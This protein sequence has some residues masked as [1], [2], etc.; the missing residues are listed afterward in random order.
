MDGGTNARHSPV[1]FHP[2]NKLNQ[3]VNGLF[4]LY[5][6]NNLMKG[7]NNNIKSY[8]FFIQVL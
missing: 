1:A 7:K 2:L 8:G 6:V 3:Y 5:A 4:Y